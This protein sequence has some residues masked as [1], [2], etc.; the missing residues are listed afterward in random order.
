MA[1]QALLFKRNNFD[2]KG[3]EYYLSLN[4]CLTGQKLIIIGLD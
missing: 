1:T 2:I 3:C 4:I